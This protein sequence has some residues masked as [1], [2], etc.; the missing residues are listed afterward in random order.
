MKSFRGQ[1]SAV[2]KRISYWPVNPNQRKLDGEDH[3]NIHWSSTSEMGRFLSLSMQKNFST[4]VLGNFRSLNTAI[5]YLGVKNRDDRIRRLVGTPLRNFAKNSCG[6]FSRTRIPNMRA[7]IMH[8]AYLRLIQDKKKLA[9]F[10]ACDLPFDSYHT[11]DSGLRVREDEA[12]WLAR[13]YDAIRKALKDGDEPDFSD[14][15]DKGHTSVYEG[16]LRNLTTDKSLIRIPDLT[17]FIASHRPKA[18]G[19]S[20]HKAEDVQSIDDAPVAEVNSAQTDQADHST[21]APVVNCGE[22]ACI[23]ELPLGDKDAN[24]QEC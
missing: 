16:I 19:S 14:I 11:L 1:L 15:Y 4:P 22:S 3:I 13:G 8:T 20:G 23:D 7:V 2:R 17:E 10:M 18:P 6:G 24:G 9:A 21:A 5:Y 12:E